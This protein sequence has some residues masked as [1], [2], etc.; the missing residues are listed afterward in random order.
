MY[1]FIDSYGFFDRSKFSGLIRADESKKS[2]LLFRISNVQYS[3]ESGHKLVTI[4]FMEFQGI[5][6]NVTPRI[7]LEYNYEKH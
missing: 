4:V 3:K 2:R 5:G 1:G 7:A 6:M